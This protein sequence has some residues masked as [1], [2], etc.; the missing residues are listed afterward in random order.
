MSGPQMLLKALIPGFDPAKP[1]SLLTSLFPGIDPAMVSPERLTG[2][3]QSA[4]NF[5]ANLQARLTAIENQNA[6]IIELLRSQQSE[7]TKGIFDGT[8]GTAAGA[9]YDERFVRLIE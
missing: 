3:V 1:A 6:T 2:M 5:G 7:Q 4:A 9:A 8:A